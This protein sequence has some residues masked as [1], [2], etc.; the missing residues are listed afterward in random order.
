MCIRDSF[1]SLKSYCHSNRPF[2][3]SSQMISTCPPCPSLK[4][5][6]LLSGDPELQTKKRPHT[7]GYQF[8]NSVSQL[9]KNLLSKN[10]NYIRCIKPNDTKQPN[11]YVAW[12]ATC[13]TNGQ[14]VWSFVNEGVVLSEIS[15]VS[16]SFDAPL[17]RHQVAYLGLFENVR[18]RRAGFAYR[19]E[20]KQ[21]LDRYTSCE[22]ERDRTRA[23]LF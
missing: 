16:C 1:D 13:I 7:M 10:P 3:N 2:T 5:N 4:T 9:M 21:A 8:R 23:I 22:R 12:I 19:Q 11:K 14:T 17:V 18:V 20:Y 6:L 15:C